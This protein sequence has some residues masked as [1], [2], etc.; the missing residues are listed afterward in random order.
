MNSQLNTNTTLTVE[1]WAEITIKEW[2]KKAAAMGISPD[3]PIAPERFVYH[4]IPAANGDPEKIQ[5]MFDY[6]LYFVD[7]GVGK[8]VNIRN[9]DMLVGIGATN[10]R[11]KPWFTSVFYTQVKILT[12]LLAEKYALKAANVIINQSKYG[13]EGHVPSPKSSGDTKEH[14]DR[15]TGEKKIT[16]KQLLENRKNEGW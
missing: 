9:R 7:W 1:A 6:Y 14:F 12:N 2:V 4:V 5:F 10:R 13:E 16:K 15:H 11:P 3:N 8:G